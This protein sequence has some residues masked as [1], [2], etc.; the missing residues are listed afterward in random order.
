M[1]VRIVKMTFKVEGVQ[2]FLDLF[3]AYKEQIRSQEGCS[4]LELIRD[5]HR[6]HVFF[7]YSFWEDE[8]YLEKYKDSEVFGQVWPKTKALF[9]EKPEAWST[10][11]IH[12]I[13]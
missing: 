9:S 2:D 7:T 11:Q 10:R 3:D 4:R 5:I 1:L 12:V 13:P 8:S 6:E